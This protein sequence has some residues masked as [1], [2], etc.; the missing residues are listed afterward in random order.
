METGINQNPARNFLLVVNSNQSHMS[1][2]FADVA[3]QRV[4]ACFL[5]FLPTV[6]LFEALASDVPLAL[7]V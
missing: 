5:P 6:V 4:E 2:C 7:M 1:H 3:T